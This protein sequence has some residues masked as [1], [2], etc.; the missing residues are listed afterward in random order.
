M[1]KLIGLMVA[2]LPNIAFAHEGHGGLGLFHHAYDILP[3]LVGVVIIAGVWY[4]KR[5]S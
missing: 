5:D 4:W 3:L 2:G 1:K